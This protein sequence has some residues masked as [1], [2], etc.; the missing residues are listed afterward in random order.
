[1]QLHINDNV[2]L[3][4]SL[5]PLNDVVKVQ[6]IHYLADFNDMLNKLDKLESL[7]MQGTMDFDLIRYLPGITKVSRQGQIYS[8]ITKRSYADPNYND[9]TTLEFNIVFPANHYTNFNSM[10]I[11]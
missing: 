9:K 6:S 2:Q 8:I 11:L 10:H 5:N 7:Y 3:V 4:Q 1:M